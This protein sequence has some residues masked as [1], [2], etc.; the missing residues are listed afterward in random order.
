[1]RKVNLISI[2]T[3]N[4]DSENVLEFLR[5]S[6]YFVTHLKQINVVTT[7]CE[8]AKTLQRKYKIWLISHNSFF[9]SSS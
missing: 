4:S 5:N 9:L 1:M 6:L 8:I 3:T 7:R 2:S